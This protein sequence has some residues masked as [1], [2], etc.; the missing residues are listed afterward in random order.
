MQPSW[1]SQVLAAVS[2]LVGLEDGTIGKC[3]AF[4]LQLSF[5]KGPDPSLVFFSANLSKS[6]VKGPKKTLL[7][8]KIRKTVQK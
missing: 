1:M 5:S 7:F 2:P 3:L 6:R 4:D 8:P